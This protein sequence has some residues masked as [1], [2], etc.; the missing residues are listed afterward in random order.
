[1][2]DDAAGMAHDSM[3]SRSYS[4]GVTRIASPSRVTRRFSVSMTRPSHFELRRGAGILRLVAQC[5]ADPG[6]QLP[7]P[8]DFST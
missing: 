2:S 7:M 5:R 8:K 6:D 3:A 4:L 1:M